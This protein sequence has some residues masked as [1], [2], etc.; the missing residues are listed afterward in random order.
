[1]HPARPR[2]CQALVQTGDAFIPMAEPRT[3]PVVRVMAMF[4]Q[5]RSRADDLIRR[6]SREAHIARKANAIYPVP[7]AP[8][9]N[10]DEP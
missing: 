3:A 9:L 1:M 8:H 5:L 7:S 4:Q 10:I 6:A 2:Q